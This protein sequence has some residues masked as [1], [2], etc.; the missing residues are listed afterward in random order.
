MRAGHDS[1]PRAFGDVPRAIS[2][3]PVSGH[4]R[5]AP[6]ESM[7]LKLPIVKRGRKYTIFVTGSLHGR[8]RHRF[9]SLAGA[10]QFLRYRAGR[11]INEYLAA[12]HGRTLFHLIGFSMSDIGYGKNDQCDVIKLDTP[13]RIRKKQ[14]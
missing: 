7:N 14:A 13:R 1:D 8:G 2:R 3:S 12:G 5:L 9:E 4:W 6:D 10:E 11:W